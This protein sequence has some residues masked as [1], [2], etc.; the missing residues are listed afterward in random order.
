MANRHLVLVTP[1]KTQ[2]RL[3]ETCHQFLD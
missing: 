1:C 3:R 2:L